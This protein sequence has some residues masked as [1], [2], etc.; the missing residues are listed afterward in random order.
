MNITDIITLLFTAYI[1]VDM[2]RYLRE[3]QLKK[4]FMAFRTLKRYR[5]IAAILGCIVL[6]FITFAI[7]ILAYQTGPLARWS[8]LY[9]LQDPNHPKEQ[10]GNLMTS[11]LKIP[12]FALIFFP[13]LALNVPRLAK[14]E[15]EVFRHRIRSPKEAIIKSIKF[16]FVHAFVGVPI[17]FCIALI[18]PG[19][20]FSWVY[21]KGGT[22]LS[23]A[24]HAIYNY[25]I[26]TVA[27][28]WMY[29][30]PLLQQLT[31]RN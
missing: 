23:T 6:I 10:A 7:G 15:E 30:I 25:I 28:T 27:F 12:I 14:R 19:L 13:L 8:W 3:G 16:G 24:W 4:D 11:G 22:R 2:A 9:L 1:T 31:P 26:L 20:W 29:G 18:V 5:W 17:A 21:S